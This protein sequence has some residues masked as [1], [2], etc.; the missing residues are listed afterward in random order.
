MTKHTKIFLRGTVVAALTLSCFAKTPT[1]TGKVVAYDPLLHAAKSATFA[2]NKEAL[3]LEVPSRKT[4]YI[5]LLFV[6]FGTTQVDRQYFDGSAPLSAK[7]I[8]DKTCDERF[9][10]FV[11]QLGLDQKT[12]TYLLTDAFKNSPAPKIKNLECYDATQKK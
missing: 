7:A 2:A 9:P 8:R 11:T 10:R 1:M 12:G 3:I 5:K 4:R 6:S